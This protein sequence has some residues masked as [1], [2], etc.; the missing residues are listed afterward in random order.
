[1]PRKVGI[2]EPERQYDQFRQGVERG[3]EARQEETEE[4]TMRAA[5]SP[6]VA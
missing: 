4:P 2:E 3:N 5:R 1:M 6:E